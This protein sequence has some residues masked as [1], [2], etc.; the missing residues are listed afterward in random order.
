MVSGNSV[1]HMSMASRIIERETTRLHASLVNIY[2]TKISNLNHIQTLHLN[3][4]LQEMLVT[5][6]NIKCHH[7]EAF[8]KVQTSEN[9]RTSNSIPAIN[10][11]KEKVG[12]R[13]DRGKPID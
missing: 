3:N 11:L 9:Y 13:K 1:S 10:K 12:G 4:K 7:A 5:E 6:K 2:V 8:C